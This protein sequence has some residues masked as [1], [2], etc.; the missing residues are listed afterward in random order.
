M[1]LAPSD[2]HIISGSSLIASSTFCMALSLQL[3]F[4][5]LNQHQN[6]FLNACHLA[7]AAERDTDTAAAE[8]EA[9]AVSGAADQNTYLG[10]LSD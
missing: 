9:A 3:R 6:W 7:A 2:A 8:E 1:T 10:R 4:L 5:R